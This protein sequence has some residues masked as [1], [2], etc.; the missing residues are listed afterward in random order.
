MVDMVNDVFGRA[1]NEDDPESHVG[2]SMSI[3]PDE[4]NDQGFVEGQKDSPENIRYKKLMEDAVKPLCP[5]CR[6]EHTKLSVTVDLLSMKARYQWSTK[7][8][9]EL[10][11]MIKDILPS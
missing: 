10:L 1:R 2:G 6:V 4:A 7:S 5:S 9:T 11:E 3:C 8:F